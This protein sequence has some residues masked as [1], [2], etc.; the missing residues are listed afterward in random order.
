[1]RERIGD[2]EG[3]TVL[4]PPGQG[5]LLTMIDRK[6]RYLKMKLLPCKEAETVRSAVC[7]T[8]SCGLPVRSMT[9]DNGSEFARF[10]EMRNGMAVTSSNFSNAS[11]HSTT[12]FMNNVKSGSFPPIIRTA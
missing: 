3:D 5:G 12:V 8:L 10:R 11:R 7:R 1:M 4:G 2:R 9:F 6:S